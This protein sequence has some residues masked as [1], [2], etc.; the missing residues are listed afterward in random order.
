MADNL[1]ELDLSHLDTSNV[2]FINEMLCEVSVDVDISNFQLFYIYDFR[3]IF[4]S[5]R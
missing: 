4:E 1:E 5:I 3:E 2:S